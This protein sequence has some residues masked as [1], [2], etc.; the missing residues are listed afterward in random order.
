MI[1]ARTAHQG[2]S[3]EGHIMI[4]TT[5]RRLLGALALT[6]ALAGCGATTTT[7]GTAEPAAPGATTGVEAPA[8]PES[9]TSVAFL[10]ETPEFSLGFPEEPVSAS[11]E[12]PGV[13]GVMALT[14]TV[15]T[16]TYAVTAAV[17]D[18]PAS[19]TLPEP[20]VALEGARD[21]ALANVPGS[22]LT[23][24]TPV[25]VQGRP[26][27]DVVAEVEGGTYRARL[28]LD[29]QRLYQLLTVGSDDRTTE[30]EEFVSSF[31]LNS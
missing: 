3:G 20:T 16:S 2:R 5:T 1:W 26:G 14:Y 17:I 7:T 18:Y 19:I 9:P 22:S 13:P 23:S 28:V 25:E 8:A 11:Q 4:G 6:A 24:S 10:L 30:H 15:E 29:G 21:G 31:V 12:I 27:L